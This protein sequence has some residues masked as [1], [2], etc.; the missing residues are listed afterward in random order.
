MVITRKIKEKILKDKH[1]TTI[2]SIPS[3]FQDFKTFKKNRFECIICD[4]FN[5]CGKVKG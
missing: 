2:K 4:F 5:D 3:C 1:K